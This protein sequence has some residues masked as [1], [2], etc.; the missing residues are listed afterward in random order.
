V[1]GPDGGDDDGDRRAAGG[2]EGVVRQAD[3]V[4]R[5]VGSVVLLLLLLLLRAAMAGWRFV[6]AVVLN[7]RRAVRPSSA[8]GRRDRRSSDAADDKMQIAAGR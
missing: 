3:S 7:V 2:W 8:D 1:H 4:V 5:L 6:A